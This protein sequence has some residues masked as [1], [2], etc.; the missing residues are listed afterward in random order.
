MILTLRGSTSEIDI[1][2]FFFYPPNALYID[3]IESPILILSPFRF[4]KYYRDQ[5]LG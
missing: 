2:L 4:N 1:D 3:R 5:G